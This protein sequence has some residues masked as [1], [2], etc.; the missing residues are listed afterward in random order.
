[1][2]YQLLLFPYY[3]STGSYGIKSKTHDLI[4]N[5][6]RLSTDEYRMLHSGMF[7]GV[8]P[9]KTREN[10]LKLWAG[11]LLD[12]IYNGEYYVNGAGSLLITEKTNN[13]NTSILMQEYIDK[14]IQLAPMFYNLSTGRS[15]T[16]SFYSFINYKRVTAPIDIL[17]H[18]SE[19]AINLIRIKYPS[20]VLDDR[21]EF[22]LCH[23][24]HP[25]GHEHILKLN[26]LTIYEKGRFLVNRIPLTGYTD[27]GV[28]LR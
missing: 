18:L 9:F 16:T 8:F 24:E 17:K 10:I 4:K 20:L 1:M 3:G 28:P 23:A 27:V 5:S 14:H 6:F 26:G 25:D 15:Q 19:N 22:E 7:G 12:I 2:T 11:S 13:S 21:V